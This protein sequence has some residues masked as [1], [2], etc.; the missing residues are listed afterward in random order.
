[1]LPR[2]SVCTCHM[3]HAYACERACVCACVHVYMCVYTLCA[4][5][6]SEIKHPFQDFLM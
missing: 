3:T 6:I 4:Y 1:M 5:V 2:G